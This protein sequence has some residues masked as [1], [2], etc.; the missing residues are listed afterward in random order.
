MVP[1]NIGSQGIYDKMA[2]KHRIQC[3]PKGKKDQNAAGGLSLPTKPI[4]DEMMKDILVLH[5]LNQIKKFSGL[6]LDPKHGCFSTLFL[7]GSASCQ[8]P[9]HVQVC[10]PV[11]S[12]PHVF[13]FIRTRT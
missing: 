4:S 3:S 12:C 8:M 10:A 2:D 1:N 6:L 7:Y 5:I 11:S 13:C 9:A